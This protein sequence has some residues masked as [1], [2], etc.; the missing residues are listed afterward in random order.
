MGGG[1]G[2]GVAGLERERGGWRE[3]GDGERERVSWCFE[4]KRQI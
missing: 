1:G 2:G 4:E 3:K